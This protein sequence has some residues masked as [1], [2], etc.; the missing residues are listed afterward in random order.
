MKIVNVGKNGKV[1]T[2][3]IKRTIIVTDDSS[4]IVAVDIGENGEVIN[5][6]ADG[7]QVMT[8]DAFKAKLE[9]ERQPLLQELEEFKVQLES[10]ENE[11]AK[12]RIKRELK[13]IEE[14]TQ[15]YDLESDWKLE[16]AIR[17]LKE[18]CFNVGCGVIAGII[19]SM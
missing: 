13:D 2:I 19:T 1:G 14:L 9:K 18:T 15:K 4:Q 7:N 11:L 16:R 3:E 12:A 8:P 17:L 10:I 6:N 5:I